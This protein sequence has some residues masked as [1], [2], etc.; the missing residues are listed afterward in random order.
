VRV[1]V[2]ELVLAQER[3]P[4][5]GQAQVWEQEQPLAQ[6]L[7]SRPAWARARTML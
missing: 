7:V 1:R 2:R 3:V 5:P 6:A 4:E